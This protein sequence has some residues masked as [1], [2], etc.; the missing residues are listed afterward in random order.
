MIPRDTLTQQVYQLAGDYILYRGQADE[1]RYYLFNVRDGKI[2]RLNAVSYAMLESFGGEET[3][4]GIAVK[5]SKRFAAGID[6]IRNDLTV[7]ITEWT[8]RG[9]LIPKG[10]S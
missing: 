2:F 9:I 4:E 1:D 3:V 8:N 5:L 6:E 10:G 7:M